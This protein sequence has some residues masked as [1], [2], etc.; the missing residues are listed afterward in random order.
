M[1]GQSILLAGPCGYSRVFV[2][3][4]R[5]K[6]RVAFIQFTRR[7]EDWPCGCS[8]CASLSFYEKAF[9]VIPS[10]P[11]YPVTQVI[12]GAFQGNT[13]IT[14]VVE[15]LVSTPVSLDIEPGCVHSGFERE[16]VAAC[17][18]LCFRAKDAWYERGAAP[19]FGLLCCSR[20][21]GLLNPGKRHSMVGE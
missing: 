11:N 14:E 13:V 9:H 6:G 15:V 2:A 18:V 3:T 1:A 8:T 17:T 5:D 16:A 7:D 12:T 4:D 20:T 21:T 19:L 10:C